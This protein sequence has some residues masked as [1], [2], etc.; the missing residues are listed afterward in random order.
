MVFGYLYTTCQQCSKLWLGAEQA[1]SHLIHWLSFSLTDICV[2][3]LQWVNKKNDDIIHD[4]CSYFWGN[5]FQAEYS[6]VKSHIDIDVELPGRTVNSTLRTYVKLTVNGP[7]WLA[8]L[9]LKSLVRSCDTFHIRFYFII[10]SFIDFMVFSRAFRIYILHML[11]LLSALI[12]IAQAMVTKEPLQQNMFQ[13]R[14]N[15]TVIKDTPSMPVL[16]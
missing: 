6:I 12:V 9:K 1:K 10:V 15:K 3:R 2:T 16:K 5:R 14:L 4:E 13:W 7:P 11:R 8:L